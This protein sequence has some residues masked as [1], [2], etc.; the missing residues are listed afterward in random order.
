MGRNHWTINSNS[1]DTI[2]WW[3]CS[4]NETLTRCADAWIE[5][6]KCRSRIRSGESVGKWRF[7]DILNS[8]D[9][10]HK[11]S[12]AIQIHPLWTT[13]EKVE[14]S[15]QDQ[16][17]IVLKWKGFPFK[18]L[19]L[20]RPQ[21]LIIQITQHVTKAQMET[22]MEL[23]RNSWKMTKFSSGKNPGEFVMRSVLLPCQSLS[24]K[25]K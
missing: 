4:R 22:K 16:N 9:R 15:G 5:V 21:R 7:W 13:S 10:I 23:F 11:L 3:N 17:R 18:I 14:S 8:L 19:S 6:R 25:R 24:S 12:I 2:D 20:W 1:E